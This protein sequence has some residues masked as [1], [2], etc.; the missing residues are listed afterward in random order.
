MPTFAEYLDKWLKLSTVQGLKNPLVKMPMKRFKLLS[1]EEFEI[2][3]LTNALN[4]RPSIPHPTLW[5]V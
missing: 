2:E 1:Q 4:K 5:W 3:A